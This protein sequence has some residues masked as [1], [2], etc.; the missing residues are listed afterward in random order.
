MP[1]G[2]MPT[3]RVLLVDDHLIFRHGVRA[4]LEGESDLAI[5]GEVAGAGE[6]IPALHALHADV[7]LLDIQLLACRDHAD[8]ANLGYFRPT[9]LGRGW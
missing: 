4:V 3:T 8:L 7:V 9:W 5:A 1:E 2:W 6:V